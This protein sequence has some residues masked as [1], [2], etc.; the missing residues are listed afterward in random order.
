M[1]KWR[2]EYWIY[3]DEYEEIEVGSIIVA[4]GFQ[5]FDPSIITQYGYGRYNNV[6]TVSSITKS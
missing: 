5:Q 6:I 1:T 3:E 4:T 2:T